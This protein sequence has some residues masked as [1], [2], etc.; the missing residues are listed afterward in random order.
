MSGIAFTF[1]RGKQVEEHHIMNIRYC[2]SYI[3]TLCPSLLG[4]DGFKERVCANGSCGETQHLIL[5]IAK[6]R[7]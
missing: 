2:I 6:S 4:M 7:R 5:E 3:E 1:I